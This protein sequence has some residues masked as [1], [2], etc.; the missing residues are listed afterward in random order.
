MTGTEEPRFVSDYAD[1]FHAVKLK[2]RYL[3]EKKIDGEWVLMA[4]LGEHAE[5]IED[6]CWAFGGVIRVHD[7]VTPTATVE[8]KDFE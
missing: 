8:E 7:L 3:V 5:R 6:L 1:S 4:R 2:I